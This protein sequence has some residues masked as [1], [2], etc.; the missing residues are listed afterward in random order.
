MKTSLFILVL[1]VSIA[2][3]SCNN[4]S[5]DQSKNQNDAAATSA[6][7]PTPADQATA[8]QFDINKLPVSDK[9][10]GAFPFF[11][12]PEGLEP[13][14]KPI[15]RKYDR[16]FFPIDS[17]MAPIEGMVWKSNV[18]SK[19]GMDSWSLP[20]FEKSYDEAIL[21]AGGVKIFDGKVSQK[22][23]DRIKDQATYFGE[24]GSIDYWNEPV[25]VY[26]IHRA[27]GGDIYIQISGNTAGGEIQILQKTPFKQTITMLK[28]DQI[29]KDLAE[30]GKAV[31]H[32]N[33]EV[34]KAV[35]QP[36]G[37]LAVDE[38]VKALKADN[39]LHIAINGYTDNTGNETHNLQLSKDRATAVMQAIIASGIDKTRLK[40][41]G[42]GSTNPI[43]NNTTEEGKAQNRRVELVKQ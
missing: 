24:D 3:F 19:S 32:I 39:N 11:S 27:D 15:Q 29:A 2:C 22:E 18:S 28:A 25:R 5:S 30:K 35:L 16:L 26:A 9:D 4:T 20:F 10:L 37:K 41:E 36:E 7:Q 6:A 12:L 14:N 17:V 40:S 33:F 1:F 31:L 43:A 42:F 8:T 23:L 21:N 13:Q 34:D 38:I